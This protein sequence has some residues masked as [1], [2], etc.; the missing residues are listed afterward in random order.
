MPDII[1]T[2]IYHSL[3]EE[4]GEF[5]KFGCIEITNGL[6]WLAAV[7]RQH[8]YNVEII[9]ALPLKLNNN[10]LASEIAK[11]SPKY[12][13]ITAC[14]IDIYGAFD[15]AS[16]L[17]SIRPDI[18]TI[19]G[20]A[21]I[22]A[23]PRET[24]ERFPSFDI[25][26]IGEGENTIIDLLDSLEEKNGKKLSDVNGII[27]RDAGNISVTNPLQSIVDM[28]SLP[29]PAW[30]LLPNINKY[31]FAPPWTMHSG[32]TVTIITSRGCP[33]QC[34]YCDRKIFGNKVRFHSAEYVKDMIK[35]L[36]FKYGILHFRIA[37][38]NFIVNKKRLREIC[39][40]LRKE[41]VKV[42]WS[43]LARV[44]SIDSETLALMKKAGC[45]SIAFGIETGSQKIHDF[46]KKKVTLE[47]IESAVKLTRKA[48]IRTIG[49]NI[50]G[51]PLE[52]IDTIKETINFNKKIKIDD[53]KT[54]F[55]VPFP[56]SELYQI[57][58]QYGTF[59]KDWKSMSVFQ[60]PV[61]VPHGLTK[62]DLIK[63]NK[64][65]F[66]SFYLQPRIIFSYLTNIRS[67]SE[68]K[69]ILIG[70]I[71]LMKWKI[72]ELFCPKHN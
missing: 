57:A 59:N 8:K 53:F 60:E 2:R 61:F 58:E 30:D 36:H 14:S 33:Y 19:L 46:E 51:H 3:E 63:W 35:T 34:I 67:L 39:D 4:F 49:F 6:C 44:D 50:I 21:H 18:V 41:N 68:I 38:D 17:K 28:D 29:L 54:Q 65:G 27:Y 25:G 56:G 69:A 16:K 23:V 1:F 70:G 66:W 15:F 37:D 31:Y 20:G 10:D 42:T 48:G 45:W 7:V 13:G 62:E 32:K 12:V 5:S 72:K 9:D 11:K 43:C 26:V 52:T 47:K 64:K 24:M 71:T 40:L 55:M 22:T